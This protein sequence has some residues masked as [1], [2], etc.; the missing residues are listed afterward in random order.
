VSYESDQYLVDQIHHQVEKDLTEAALLNHDWFG[1][2]SNHQAGDFGNLKDYILEYGYEEVEDSVVVTKTKTEF[3]GS[4][5]GKT[6]TLPVSGTAGR[7]IEVFNTGTV[8]VSISGS[9]QLEEL[10]PGESACFTDTGSSWI[11]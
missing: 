8:V 2:G 1:F 4:V 5:T 6:I 10:Y 3:T 9:S 11:A 7:E